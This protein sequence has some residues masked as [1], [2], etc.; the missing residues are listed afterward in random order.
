[1][2]DMVEIDMTDIPWPVSLLTCN[3]RVKEMRQGD[4]VVFTLQDRNLMEN[5]KLLFDAMPEISY[6]V[7]NTG[8][9][10]RLVIRK[11]R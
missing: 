4:K 9:T 2:K 6:R 8:D 3:M 5:L 11:G 7:F 10:C 1:M